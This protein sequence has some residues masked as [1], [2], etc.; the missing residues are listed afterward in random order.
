M[1]TSACAHSLRRREN[2]K[3]LDLDP[4]P[5][6]LLCPAPVRDKTTIL[7][8]SP[9]LHQTPRTHI[10]MKSDAQYA[11]EVILLPSLFT[12]PR[13]SPMKCL[14]GTARR[15]EELAGSRVTTGTMM[16]TFS[17]VMSSATIRPDSW[18]VL[19]ISRVRWCVDIS[20]LMISSHRFASISGLWA[21]YF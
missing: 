14:T 15:G 8:F 16:S 1:S 4:M 6:V 12:V 13:S 21:Q 17:S 10:Q 20:S 9:I 11:G 3:S 7:L 2:N 19:K 18:P 5:A